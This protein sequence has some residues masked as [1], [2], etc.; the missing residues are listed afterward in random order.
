LYTIIFYKYNPLVFTVFSCEWKEGKKEKIF[1]WKEERKI[2]G[3]YV[4]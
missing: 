3:K 1:H 2:E 4:K